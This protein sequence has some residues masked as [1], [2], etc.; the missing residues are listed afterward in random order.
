MPCPP[1]PLQAPGARRRAPGRLDRSQLLQQAH[2]DLVPGADLQARRGEQQL[3]PAHGRG[4][5]PWLGW[6][7]PGT[8]TGSAHAWSSAQP[9]AAVTRPALP[10]PARS[11]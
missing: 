5:A 11:S 3:M 6:P 10:C 9:P 4:T 8:T 1:G 7:W 2:G